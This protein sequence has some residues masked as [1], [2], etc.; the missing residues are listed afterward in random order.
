P[1]LVR[2]NTVASTAVARDRKFAEPVAPK[3]LPEEPPPN[4]EPMS[5][6]LPCCRS[7]S[8]MITRA[9]STCRPM[10]ICV[11]ISIGSVLNFRGARRGFHYGDEIARHQRRATDQSAIHVPHRKQRRRIVRLDAAAVEKTRA[12]MQLSSQECVHLLSLLRCRRTSRT[13]RPHRFVR[14]H[15]LLQRLHSIQIQY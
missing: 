15:R 10:T 5:A 8:P 1:R 7:T 13:D 11:H 3:R 4:P 12:R 2:K 9:T 6:P 14:H